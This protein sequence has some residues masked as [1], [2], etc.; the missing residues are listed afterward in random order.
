[1]P[2]TRATWLVWIRPAMRYPG[3]GD[4]VGDAP[5]PR[6][7][8]TP[9]A[10]ALR[11]PGTPFQTLT[12]E[13]GLTFSAEITVA[14]DLRA[15]IAEV[16]AL[17]A[18]VPMAGRLHK[19]GDGSWSSVVLVENRHDAVRTGRTL[20]LVER[21][22]AL[23]RLFEGLGSEIGSC[24]IAR[25]APGDL[26]DWHH[27][28]LSVDHEMARLHLPLATIPEA[29]TDFC[30]QRVHWPAG[31]LVYGDYGFPHRVLNTGPVERIHLY[32]DVPSER[33]RPYLPDGFSDRTRL[34][35]QAVAAWLAWRAATGAV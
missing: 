6:G 12:R 16:M 22:P 2:S 28:P 32:L 17:L 19:C 25:I 15:V 27:D 13:A 10:R 5:G 26:L 4:G 34:R 18:A 20:P 11:A 14:A 9:A 21:L 23:R 29:V 30:H 8:D 1:M 24:T 35:D 7:G 3:S 31:R 33:I